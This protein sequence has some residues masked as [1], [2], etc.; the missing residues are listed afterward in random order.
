MRKVAIAFVIAAAVIMGMSII[1]VAITNGEPDGARHPY[2][3]L[4]V[5]EINGAPAWRCSGSL[6]ADNVVL[7]ARH[8]TEGADAAR[9]WF[10][11]D[12]TNDVVPF[13]LYPYGGPGSGAIEGTPYFNSDFPPYYDVGLVVLDD[14][15]DS[16]IPHAQ[17]PSA[18]LVDS[19]RNKTGIDFVGYGVQSQERGFPGGNPEFRWTGQRLRLYAPS[20]LISGKFS[21]SDLY[22]CLSLNPAGRH[23]AKSAVGTGGMCYGDSGGPTLLGGT[24][25]V[26]AVNSFGANFNCTGVGYSMRIDIPEVQDW[27]NSFLQ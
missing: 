19:L 20:E 5:F 13:P 24:D 15:A 9:V 23:A 25:T 16:A 27:I 22:M 17:L 21:S 4:L 1:S 8:C 18:G 3:G 10:N 6:I 11:E 7:T 2:V 12:L 14:P 26:L